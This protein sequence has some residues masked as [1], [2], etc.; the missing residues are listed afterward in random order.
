MA[1]LEFSYKTIADGTKAVTTAGTRV[2]L[3]AE[4]TPCRMVQIQAKPENT[5]T[6]VVG[7]STVVAASGTRRGIALVP[8]QSVALRVTDLNVLYLDSVVSGE[9]VSFV[10]FN[11]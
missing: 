4:S 6:V 9:G 3:V 2:A 7:A 1:D 11:N 5:D 8:G 10:Y